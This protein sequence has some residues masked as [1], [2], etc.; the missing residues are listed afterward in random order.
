MQARA[1]EGRRPGLALPVSVGCCLTRLL[2]AS[3]RVPAWCRS[4]K[5]L[6]PKPGLRG[7]GYPISIASESMTRGVQWWNGQIELIHGR[8]AA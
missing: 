8:R 2:Q 5:I 1:G 3:P 6:V 7:V 4:G